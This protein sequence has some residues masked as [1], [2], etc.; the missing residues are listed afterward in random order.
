MRARVC[1][2]VRGRAKTGCDGDC[3]LCTEGLY[4]VSD[5][6]KL[7]L[8]EPVT[9]R[10]ICIENIERIGTVEELC[11]F[12]YVVV[13]VLPSRVP[14]S[15]CSKSR[16]MRKAPG[17]QVMATWIFRPE[18]PPSKYLSSTTPCRQFSTD[19]F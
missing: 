3:E 2:C 12:Q 16:C 6:W 18:T 1:V 9:R 11:G 19:T 15:D 5:G 8:Y 17:I 4:A 14:F 10:Y 7:H 13:H